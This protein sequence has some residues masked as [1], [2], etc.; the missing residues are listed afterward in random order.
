MKELTVAIYGILLFMLLLLETYA[1]FYANE[2]KRAENQ[3]AMHLPLPINR[4]ISLSTILPI[5]VFLA[6]AAFLFFNIFKH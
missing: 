5:I 3:L 2:V 4:L 1:L 6:I